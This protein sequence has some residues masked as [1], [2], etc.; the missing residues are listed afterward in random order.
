MDEPTEAKRTVTPR[1]QAQSVTSAQPDVM[2]KSTAE[3]N[4]RAFKPSCLR[5]RILDEKLIVTKRTHRQTQLASMPPV[6]ASQ[7]VQIDHSA[8]RDRAEY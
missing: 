8:I 1:R 5:T 6:P 4:V 2:S 3:V 7:S